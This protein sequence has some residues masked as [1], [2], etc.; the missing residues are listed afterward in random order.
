MLEQRHV[1]RFLIKEGIHPKEIPGRLRNVYGEGAMKKT[2][3]FF[4]AA[5]VRRGREDLSDEERPGRPTTRGLD[6][7]L[8]HRLEKD[9]HTT[10][11]KLATSLGISH[12]TVLNHLRDNL[13]MKCYCLRWVPH[14]LGTIKN[15]RES[16]TLMRLSRPL[17]R[18]LIGSQVWIR[19]SRNLTQIILLP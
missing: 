17:L 1:I 16:V 5:E 13:K 15:R 2:Q 10:A 18:N 12:Q 8:A 19:Y 4:W 11:R 9:P 6:E 7:I 3:V 14:V